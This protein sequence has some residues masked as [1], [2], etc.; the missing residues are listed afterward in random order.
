MSP[1]ARRAPS[2]TARRPPAGGNDRSADDGLARRTAWLELDRT[3]KV[4]E[5]VARRILRDIVRRQLQPGDMLPAEAV[6]LQQFGVGRASLREALRILEIH[7]V[8][9]I[10]PG[11]RGGP[12]VAPVEAADYARSMTV[13]LFRSGATYRDLCEARLIME[14]VM[15]AQAAERATPE[16]RQALVDSARH[17]HDLMDASPDEW[18]ESSE[19]FH[20]LLAAASG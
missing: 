16:E 8:I 18:S 20:F 2:T 19:G 7:G 17:T 13:F 10:K 3:E 15:A 6:M 1:A 5:M 12:M 4:P 11:P 9:R 14:P